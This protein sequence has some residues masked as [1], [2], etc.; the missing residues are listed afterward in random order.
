MGRRCDLC[1]PGY[2]NL[3]ADNP[4]GCQG[5]TSYKLYKYV[6]VKSY[7][8]TSG[9][10]QVLGKHTDLFLQYVRVIREVSVAERSLSLLHVDICQTNIANFYIQ[11]VHLI[12]LNDQIYL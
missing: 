9:M 11:V 6:T 7:V 5:N 12:V 3:S 2:H 10:N 4:V 1:K 8:V